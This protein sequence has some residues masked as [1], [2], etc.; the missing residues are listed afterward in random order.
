MEHAR[1]YREVSGGVVEY[2]SFVSKDWSPTTESG[3]GGR[4]NLTPIT[5]EE[6]RAIAPL[7]VPLE[8]SS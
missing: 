8:T 4:Q 7:A 3:Y 1:L 5:A 2:W 6:A